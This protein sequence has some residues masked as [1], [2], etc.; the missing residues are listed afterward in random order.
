METLTMRVPTMKCMG[1]VNAIT[2]GLK[3]LSSTLEVGT[4][5]P[6]FTVTVKYNAEELTPEEIY[7]KMKDLGY[8][9]QNV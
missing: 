8:P 1:C 9:A 2:N 3:A 7:N 5:L 4:D 6:S